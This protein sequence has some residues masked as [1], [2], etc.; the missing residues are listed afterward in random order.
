M[1]P[2]RVI[3][4]AHMKSYLS[5]CLCAASVLALALAV[6]PGGAML[7][8]ALA[9]AATFTVTKTDDTDDGLCDADCSLREAITA[10]GNAAAVPCGGSLVCD[11]PPETV[12][13]PPGTY[14]IP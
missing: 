12:I 10:A 11:V 2:R 8:P 1:H 6:L 9:Q 14:L 5:R 4:E 3:K 7:A 13:V